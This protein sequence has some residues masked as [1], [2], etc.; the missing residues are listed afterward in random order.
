M[1]I[2]WRLAAAIMALAG[3]AASAQEAVFVDVLTP[4]GDRAG[5][6]AY[7][8]D[9]SVAGLSVEAHAKAFEPVVVLLA[10]D[11][12]ATV[13]RGGQR[14]DGETGARGDGVSVTLPQGV[15]PDWI[16]A[17]APS[18]PNGAGAFA[19]VSENTL[20]IVA[21]SGAQREAA[22]QR[23][24]SALDDRAPAPA[25]ADR[26]TGRELQ[27]A[28]NDLGFDAGAVDGLV[29][30]RTRT[31]LRA[32]QKSLGAPATGALTAAQRD[33]LLAERASRAPPQARLDRNAVTR[34]RA[35]ATRGVMLN[36]A[37]SP[38]P[39]ATP[40]GEAIAGSVG[41]SVAMAAPP[42]AQPPAARQ[43]QQSVGL[44]AMKPWAPPRPSDR[45]TVDRARLASALGD[46]PR[47]LGG[48]GDY[49]RSELA[50]AGYSDAVYLGVPGGFAIMTR[51][52]QID[53]LGAPLPGADRYSEAIAWEAAPFWNLW[54][55]YLALIKA[56]EGY[57]RTLTLIVTD[58]PFSPSGQA[59][60]SATFENWWA[61]AVSALPVDVRATPFTDNHEVSVL[62]YRFTKS[63][64]DAP[65][66]F[67][68]D[69]SLP[70]KEQLRH[71]RL[72]AL[73]L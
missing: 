45:G 48:V 68:N 29:G 3:V 46:R 5:I 71:V 30:P 64:H 60:D 72:S 17:V 52:E 22:R 58:Q 34:S 62:V 56:P 47:T 7:A 43:V 49:L 28:L 55:L 8:L 18:R 13:F 54:E 39:R 57:F 50:T 6:R 10:P 12:R 15:G 42:P 36:S 25:Q 70:V 40:P 59:A 63:E 69:R 26:Q 1:K 31:A 73:M 19:L 41:S 2:V 27:A 24:Q 51:I 44:P 53:D 16:L 61:E 20:P 65:P 37:V 33:A 38:S 32:Y 21:L 66:E 14:G 35:A 11:G 4:E 9:G 67:V 23:V